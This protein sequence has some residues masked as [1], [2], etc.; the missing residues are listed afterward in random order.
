MNPRLEK[1]RQKLLEEGLD[2]IFIS[3]A[4]NRR[5]LSGFAGTAGYLLIS[6]QDAV[7]ATDFRYT[8]QAAEQAPD[9]RI[10]RI[11]GDMDGWVPALVLDSEIRKLGFEASDISFSVFKKLSGSIEKTGKGISLTP[12]E[13]IVD[14][15]RAVKDTREIENIRE[16]ARLADA[17]FERCLSVIRP[18]ITEKELAWEM[19]KFMR[20]AGGDAPPFELIVASGSNAAMPHHRPGSREISRGEP[21]IIDIGANINGYMSDL[22]RTVYLGQKDKTFDTLYNI[23]LEAQ[24]AAIDNISAGRTAGDIDGYAREIISGAGHGEDFG[25]GLGHGVGLAAHEEP[26]IGPGSS[27]VLEDNMVFTVEPGIYIN[28]WGGIRIE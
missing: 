23:V 20:Q 4:E 27:T 1:T 21:V 14:R 12:T 16:A 28:G 7:L 18:G 15:L 10:I 22:S 26:R 11:S 8:E 3:Q 19:E 24:Q 9:F 6:I 25:H 13:G 17:A 5:Y 2:A